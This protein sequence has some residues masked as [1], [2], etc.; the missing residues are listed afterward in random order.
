MQLWNHEYNLYKPLAGITDKRQEQA[1]QL[2]TPLSNIAC[3]SY[4]FFV[5]PA[6]SP[7]SS[8]DAAAFRGGEHDDRNRTRDLSDHVSLEQQFVSRL[9]QLVPTP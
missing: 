5:T 9:E 3:R 1:L 6:P 2:S 7:H 4:I 8:N